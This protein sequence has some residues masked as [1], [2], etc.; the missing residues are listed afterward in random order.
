MSAVQD[1]LE[2][3]YKKCC[4]SRLRIVRVRSR[5]PITAGIVATYFSGQLEGKKTVAKIRRQILRVGQLYLERLWDL[6]RHG[7]WLYQR[8][9]SA[10]P[11]ELEVDRLVRSF[12]L[13]ACCTPR[14]V[15]YNKPRTWAK[16]CNRSN[17]CPY[18]WEATATRQI[19]VVRQLV[20]KLTLSANAAAF[21][22]RARVTSYTVDVS[23]LGGDDLA[24][25]QERYAAIVRLRAELFVCK[26]YL[27]QQHKRMQRN[28]FGSIWRIVV[29][30]KTSGFELQIRQLW[31]V[32]TAKNFNVVALP[33]SLAA[34]LYDESA[35]VAANKSWSL[36]KSTDDVDTQVYNLAIAFNTYPMQWLT[37]DID[38]VAV[39]LNATAK[40]RL[41]GGTGLFKKIGSGLIKQCIALEAEQRHDRV[42]TSSA[43]CYARRYRAAR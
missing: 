17:F 43:P 24:T 41:L 30:P 13:A 16:A 15:I 19:Q 12:T 34:V 3:A 1:A 21:T 4:R 14:S 18:C 23:N 7:V 42:K 27:Q 37:D 22:V 32:A 5:R 31:V 9:L 2:T 25:P 36:R 29:V 8:G 10:A 39:Y 11:D 6:G 33:C 26:Q 40:T 38:L 28:T 20:N 35:N